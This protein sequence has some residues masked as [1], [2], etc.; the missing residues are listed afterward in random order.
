M[1]AGSATE[2]IQ[3]KTS[4]DAFNCR[5]AALIELDNKETAVLLRINHMEAMPTARCGGIE[6]R[7][8]CGFS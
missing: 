4:T 2:G 8:E 1:P 5:L 7:R 6:N 3:V